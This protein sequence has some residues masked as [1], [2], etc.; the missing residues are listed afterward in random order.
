M[1]SY[2]YL[3]A[4]HSLMLE[5]REAGYKKRIADLEAELAGCRACRAKVDCISRG[6]DPVRDDGAERIR[7]LE[8]ALAPF[9]EI[10][11]ELTDGLRDDEKNNMMW[12]VPTVGQLRAA[13]AALQPKDTAK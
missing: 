12:A 13:L 2:D 8:A 9:A 1:K 6:D 3:Q 10:A 7:E 5:A 4:P 11:T